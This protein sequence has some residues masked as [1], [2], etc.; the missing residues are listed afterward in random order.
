MTTPALVVSRRGWLM[1]ASA[2]LLTTGIG[3]PAR[4][5]DNWAPAEVIL[6]RIKAPVFAKR[7][8]DITR[9]GASQSDQAKTTAALTQAIAACAKSGGGRVVVP[10]GVWPTGPIHL[11]SKVNLHISK[12]ATLKFSTDPKDYPLVV[13]RFEGEELMNYSPLIYAYGQTD[14]AIT[15]E[16]TLDGQASDQN[17]WNWVTR[18]DA[19][20]MTPRKAA[21]D[22]LHALAEKG[23]PVAGRIFGDG[24]YLRPNFI[25]PYNCKNVLIEGV[26]IKGSPMWIV[27]PVLSQNVIVRNLRIESLG[28]NNDGCDP[29]SCRD[30]LIEGCEFICGDD[31]IA[32]KS[33]RNFDG[34]RVNVPSENIIVR[35]C[36]MKDGHGGVSLGSEASGGIRNVYVRDCH[37]GGPELLRA[38]RLKTNSYRGGYIENVVFRDVKVDQVAEGVLEVSLYYGEGANGKFYPRRVGGIVMDNVV[39][40]KSLYALD[41]RGYADLPVDSIALSNCTFRG[42]AKGNRLEHAQVKASGVTINGQAWTGT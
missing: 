10:A 24:H 9:F 33:G 30:V 15:G 38:L 26:A 14:I 35:N 5:A 1:R 40:E 2:A 6:K 27:H 19:A 7:D 42:V 37:M 4:A 12:G 25:Q 23:T 17:W 16:G 3:L 29:E 28:P 34:R 11:K 41:V 20:I 13:T 31:C 39:C 21:F 8:F 32:I 22:R 36:Q 18:K